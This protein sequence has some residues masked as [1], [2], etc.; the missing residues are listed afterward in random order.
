MS[1]RQTILPPRARSGRVIPAD[2][3]GMEPTIRERGFAMVEPCDRVPSDGIYV[4]LY[5]GD[6]II[7]RCQLLVD[8]SVRLM[9]DNPKYAAA[10]PDILP[11]AE[12]EDMVLGRVVGVVNP[13]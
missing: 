2:G 13:I 6:T 11:K 12:V 10:R 5:A 9:L 7:R 3:D 8:G 4:L 1:A